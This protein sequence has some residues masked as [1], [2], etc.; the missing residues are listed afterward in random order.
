MKNKIINN[1]LLVIFILIFVFSVVRIS[2]FLIEVNGNKKMNERLV[3]DVIKVEKV[4]ADDEEV[5]VQK[6]TVDFDSLLNINKD[7]KGWIIF[8]DE[9]VNYP[10]LQS[11]DNNYYLTHTF[12]KKKNSLG[13]I[14]MDYR[15]SSLGARNVVLYG[16]NGI[17]GAMFGSLKDVLK[18]NYFDKEENRII[19][20]LDVDNNIR[21]YEIFSVYTIN[22]ES[23]YITT[24][25]DD[26]QEYEKFLNTIKDRSIVRFDSDLSD[27]ENV[28]TLSTC[29]GAA[30]TS[31]RL[32]IHAKLK[33]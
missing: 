14:F 29:H 6:L 19:K 12:D 5:E 28:L 32:V 2:V 31:R 25:F 27:V 18:N 33:N 21:N 8:N 16:H 15:S 7:I 20:V 4:V 22:K 24:S 3:K 26:D 9:K 11:N 10:I 30:G 17:S 13:A 1:I 23:Y